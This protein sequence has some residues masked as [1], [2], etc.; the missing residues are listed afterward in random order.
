MSNLLDQW[1]AYLTAT[2][3][4]NNT[5]GIR[6]RTITALMNHA[7]V[8]DP[9]ALTRGHVITF[10]GRGIKP[11]SRLTY[12]SGIKGWCEFLRD[13]DHHPNPDLLRGIPKPKTPHPVARPIDD[14]LIAKLLRLKVSARAHAYVRLALFAGLR[15]HEIARVRTE[16]LDTANGWLMVTGKG[17]V[18]APVPLHPEI[19]KLAET[20]PQTGFWFTSP[21]DPF[22]HVNPVAVS[23]TI[24]AALR[25]V[26]STATP[27]QLRDTCATRMQRQVKDMRLTQSMLRHQSIRST[28]KYAGVADEQMQQ[29]VLSLDWGT[30]A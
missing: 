2:G 19:R 11:W 15:V 7:G 20:M 30:A 9:L 27:H 28:Q 5:V 4:T 8:R 14:E 3:C 29:A 13:F 25:Q 23:N 17:G 6:V 21:T 1:S 26:G 18:T 12:W 24:K 16:D 22:Q 10:L